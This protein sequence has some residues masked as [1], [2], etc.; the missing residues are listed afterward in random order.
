MVGK[1]HQL[2]PLCRHGLQTSVGPDGQ[3]D[4]L[5]VRGDH[6]HRHA[7]GVAANPQ[8]VAAAVR[9]RGNVLLVA[10]AVAS[11]SRSKLKQHSHFEFRKSC[12]VPH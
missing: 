8:G 11:I 3:P 5:V 1:Q 6:P 7:V 9:Y 12:H 2:L 10:V 4:H